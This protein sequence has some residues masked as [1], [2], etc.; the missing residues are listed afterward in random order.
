MQILKIKI[1]RELIY[2]RLLVY[3]NLFISKI[4]I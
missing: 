4:L 1:K 3:V 2:S